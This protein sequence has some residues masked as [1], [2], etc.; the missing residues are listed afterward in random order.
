[1]FDKLFLYLMYVC[2]FKSSYWLRV[3]ALIANFYFSSFHEGDGIKD[4][5]N[6]D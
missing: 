5:E 3:Y 4:V 6:H 1:M 2:T